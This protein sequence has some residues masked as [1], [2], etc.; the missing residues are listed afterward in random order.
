MDDWD[1][2]YDLIESKPHTPP[3]ELPEDIVHYFIKQQP[4]L[5]DLIERFDLMLEY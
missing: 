4:L 5:E 2:V 3:M 1:W